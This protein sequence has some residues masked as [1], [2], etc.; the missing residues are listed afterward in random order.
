MSNTV[1][2]LKAELGSESLNRLT[3]RLRNGGKRVVIVTDE[4]LSVLKTNLNAKRSNRK[5][6]AKKQVHQRD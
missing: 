2:I 4:F 6:E 3:D 1:Y 5:K